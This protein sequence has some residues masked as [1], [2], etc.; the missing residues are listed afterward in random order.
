MKRKLSILV[1]ILSLLLSQLACDDFWEVNIKDV[2]NNQV[3]CEDIW[4]FKTC[5]D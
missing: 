2:N 1:A 4:I 5:D 3:E